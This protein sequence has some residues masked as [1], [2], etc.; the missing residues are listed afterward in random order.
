MISQT[1]LNVRF[2]HTVPVFLNIIFKS[3]PLVAYVKFLNRRIIIGGGGWGGD[4]S[5]FIKPL[6]TWMVNEFRLKDG[7]T[8]TRFFETLQLQFVLPRSFAVCKYVYQ[9]GCQFFS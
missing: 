3:E 2:V 8:F 4:M 5:K 7:V 9:L 6:G 1:H